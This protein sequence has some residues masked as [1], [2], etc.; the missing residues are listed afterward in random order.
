MAPSKI[1][2]IHQFLNFLRWQSDVCNE[3]KQ[4]TSC[5]IYH[6]PVGKA[7]SAPEAINFPWDIGVFNFFI[8]SKVEAHESGPELTH[9]I[10]NQ[11][12]VETPA[13]NEMG[14]FVSNKLIIISSP[15]KYPILSTCCTSNPN[16]EKHREKCLFFISHI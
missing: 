16:Q 6:I 14:L 13:A 7:I 10:V 12:I 2:L 8:Q 1:L 11:E 4:D 5:V 3:T 15:S 9:S